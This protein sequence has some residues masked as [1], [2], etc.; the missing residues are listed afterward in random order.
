MPCYIAVGQMKF[1]KN[2]SLVISLLLN[3]KNSES[4]HYSL[5]NWNAYVI[6]LTDYENLES[7]EVQLK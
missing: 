2:Y 7:S 5:Q 4:I 1:F 3:P 6:N